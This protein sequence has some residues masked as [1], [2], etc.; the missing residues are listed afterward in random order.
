MRKTISLILALT[1]CFVL[2]GCDSSQYKKATNLYEEKRYEEAAAIF[3][4][5]GDYENSAEM[6][7]VCRYSYAAELLTGG[8]FEAAK[9]VFE[10]L[11]DYADSVN[12][13]KECDY[14]QAEELLA[15]GN[16]EDALMIYEAIPDYN[17]SAD[18]INAAKRELM[19]ERYADV[20]QMLSEGVWFFNGGSDAAVNS[21]V[22]SQDAAT[23][24]QTV[25][26]GNGVHTNEGS[27]FPYIIDEENITLT[28]ADGSEKV[29]PYTVDGGKIILDDGA[30][31]TPE[32]VD[33][34]L[35]GYWGIRESNYIMGITTAQEFIYFF[36]NGK[37][38]FEYAAK[39][40]N[41]SGYY[42]YGPH[43]GTYTIDKNGFRANAMNDW[44]FSFNVIDGK[45]VMERCGS[46]CTPVSGFKGQ[47]GYSF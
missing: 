12:Y 42:Y 14:Q 15:A 28:L 26:D 36:D 31:L 23:I 34:D 9:A 5:L 43:E 32:Q 29:I 39:A 22:F 13:V 3:A 46:V 35:Q 37:I 40:F 24:K 10:E 16:F 30:Y 8:D 7:K 2:V 38:V 1:M 33:V 4:E 6:V 21:I 25:S 20:I 11:G 17:D 41:A 45:A 47:N 44:Q 18:K 19:F 27:E